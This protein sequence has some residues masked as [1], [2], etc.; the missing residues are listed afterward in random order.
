MKVPILNFF[1]AI[2]FGTLI[3]I[4]IALYFYMDKPE[5]RSEIFHQEFNR[6][7]DLNSLAPPLKP[8][9]FDKAIKN[10]PNNFENYV[11][12][13]TERANAGNYQEALNDFNKAV[14]L[15]PKIDNVAY[16][17]R[18]SAKY[19][20]GDSQDAVDAYT[21]IIKSNPVP[22]YIDMAYYGL[23]TV[24]FDQTNYQ[25]AI[26][27]F[28]KAIE[29]NPKFHGSYYNRGLSKKLIGDKQGAEKDLKK[30]TELS[31]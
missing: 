20:L 10:S 12:R 27:N 3:A 24:Q 22:K 5:E 31:R 30:A 19:D 9:R 2:L 15:N 16:L 25:E 6:K 21:Q 13:G 8:S 17:N 23:G 1:A 26:K 18:A 7:I 28:D 29:I 4:P 14:E 11:S